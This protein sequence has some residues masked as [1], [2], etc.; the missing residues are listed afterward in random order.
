MSRSKASAI[1]VKDD[2]RQITGIVTDADLREK[3]LAQGLPSDTPVSGIMSSPVIT[4]SADSQVFEAF[5]TMI[6]KDKRTWPCA[7]NP[8]TSPALLRKRT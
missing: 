7:E 4:I 6:G 1:L 8:A 2:S 5:L 3:I